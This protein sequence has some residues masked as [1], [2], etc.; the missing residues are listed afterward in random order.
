MSIGDAIFGSV[1][2]VCITILVIFAVNVIRG[3]Q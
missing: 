3:E 2:V 1:L